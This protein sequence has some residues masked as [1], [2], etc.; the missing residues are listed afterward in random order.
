MNGLTVFPTSANFVLIRSE[1]LPAKELFRRL[2]D[3]HGILVRDVSD[4]PDL[5]GCLRI[6]IGT[7]ED[8]EAVVGA[9]GQIL[10]TEKK[11]AA[12]ERR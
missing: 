7:D 9:L 10:T 1:R 6:S 12:D 11:A 8:M 5:A 2:R 4:G 3:E